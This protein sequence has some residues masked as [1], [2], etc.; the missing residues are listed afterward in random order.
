MTV[1]RHC[2]PRFPFL[3][4]G[5]TQGAGRWNREGSAPVQY[6]ADTP[7][8]AWAEFLRHEEITTEEELVNIRRAIWVIQIPDSTVFASPSLPD[9]VAI[10]GLQSYRACQVEAERLRESGARGLR[11][12]SAA[13]LPGAAAGWRVSGGLHSAARQDGI[14]FALFGP[15]PDLTGWS[16]CENGYPRPDVLRHVGPLR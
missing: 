4:E 5:P 11:V 14:V 1:F 10:G 8:G 7:D 6:F 15:Q 12:R 16:A 3:W 13:L 9:A 2:D